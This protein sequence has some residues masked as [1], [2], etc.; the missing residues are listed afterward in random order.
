METITAYKADNGILFATKE[1]CLEHEAM[2]Q[3]R[4]KID[5]FTAAGMNP[6]PNNPHKT[7]AARAIVAWETYK[8]KNA[9]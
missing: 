6:Y 4:D 9:A 5:A 2:L 7:I 8:A 1:E 3:W